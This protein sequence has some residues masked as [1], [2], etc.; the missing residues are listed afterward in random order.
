[1]N[2]KSHL[3]AWAVDRIIDLAKANNQVQNDLVLLSQVMKE[4]DE[5]AAYAYVGEEDFADA[6]KRVVECLKEMP[7]ALDKVMHL[8]TEL[9]YIEEQ[10]RAQLSRS[11]GT[12]KE[13]ANAH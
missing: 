8:Q 12:V 1:M 4:A 6:C 13:A 10:M 7:D 3:K 11:N 5:L 2:Y 9:A